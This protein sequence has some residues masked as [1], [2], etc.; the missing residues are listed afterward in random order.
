MKQKF[1]ALCAPLFILSV[2]LFSDGALGREVCA[3]TAEK[4]CFTALEKEAYGK[5][6]MEG[7]IN[8]NLLAEEIGEEGAQRTAEQKGWTK[9]LG[10]EHKTPSHPQGFDQV[11]RSSDGKIH[12]IEAK[13]GTS[14]LEM[15]YGYKQGTPEWA[16]KAGESTLTSNKAT[17][18]EK[19]AAKTVLKAAGE[20]K[21]TVDVVRTKTNLGK[22][23]GTFWEAATHSTPESAQMAKNVLKT[24]PKAAPTCV[25]AESKAT[26]ATAA[27]AA[28]VSTKPLPKAATAAKTGAKALPKAATA[29]KAA[30]AAAA[31]FDVGIRV[32]EAAE[33]EN[34]YRSGEI[35]GNERAKKHTKNAAGMAGGW[36]GA[37]AGG[38]GGAAIGAAAGSV[39][40]FVGTAIGGA[41]GGI[42]GGIGGYIC[43]EKAADATVEACWD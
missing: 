15:G 35:S 21:L 2:C 4:E 11:W 24:L 1:L 36:S 10:K 33:V 37:A 3:P 28:A 29:V 12:V 5:Q 20:N 18:A 23:A 32:V 6:W 38:Y 27:T 31:A 17:A 39:V 42:V 25:T 16:V 26:A 19:E 43:G 40:P 34:Q 30:G 8:R 7:E 14:T 9:I 41:V 13:G 22:P